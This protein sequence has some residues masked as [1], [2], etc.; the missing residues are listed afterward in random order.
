VSLHHGWL[1][2]GPHEFRWDGRT[3]DGTSARNG[4]YFYRAEVGGRAVSRKMVLVR[5]D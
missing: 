2:A 4:V 5:G 3:E 1:A